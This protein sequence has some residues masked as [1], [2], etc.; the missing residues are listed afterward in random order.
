MKKIVYISCILLLSSC[1]IFKS[2][3][4]KKNTLDSVTESSSAKTLTDI[5]TSNRAYTRKWKLTFQPS[6]GEHPPLQGYQP[7]F[8]FSDFGTGDMKSAMQKLQKSYNLLAGKKPVDTS[9]VFS[10]GYQLATLE[11]EETMNEQIRKSREESQKD[12]TSNKVSSSHSSN[13]KQP[14]STWLVLG[15]VLILA[16]LIFV[17]IKR[18]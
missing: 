11:M 14:V 12:T 18:W 4:K 8:I 5:D 13:E 3:V 10:H 16:G 15:C 7:P 6:T 1:S 2:S 17:I 9:S